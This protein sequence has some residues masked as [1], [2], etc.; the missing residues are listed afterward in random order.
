MLVLDDHS[1]NKMM[2]ASSRPQEGAMNMI[3]NNPWIWLVVGL[4]PYYIS[5]QHM[6]NGCILRIHTLF[7]SLVIDYQR[8]RN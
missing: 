4:I 8:G 3:G 2:P 5:K 6:R 7:W 1:S